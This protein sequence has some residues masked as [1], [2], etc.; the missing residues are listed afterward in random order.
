MQAD[1]DDL[2]AIK[3]AFLWPLAHLSAPAEMPA[4]QIKISH[5]GRKLKLK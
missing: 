3:P 4:K 5:S 1:S 2:W